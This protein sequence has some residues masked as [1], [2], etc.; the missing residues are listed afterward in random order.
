VIKYAVTAADRYPE[1]VRLIK[2]VVSAEMRISN[3]INTGV[4]P[5]IEVR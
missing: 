1:L 5:Y 3:F 2:D 4:L